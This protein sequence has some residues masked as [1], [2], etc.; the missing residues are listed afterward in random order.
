[1]VLPGL[2]LDQA[3]KHMKDDYMQH[4]PNADTGIKGFKEYFTRLG[5]PKA[6][7]PPRANSFVRITCR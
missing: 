4:N 1:V 5:Q 3:E 2:H 7:P 6:A